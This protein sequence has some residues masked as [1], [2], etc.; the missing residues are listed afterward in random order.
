M[1]R[2]KEESVEL[3]AP[4]PVL[5]SLKKSA[6]WVEK[7]MKPI[8]GGFAAIL[9]AVLG[10]EYFVSKTERD[11]SVVTTKLTEA[12]RSY[13]EAMEPSKILSSTVAGALD[14]DY[15][16]AR[17]K[18]SAI[19]KEHPGSGASRLAKLYEADLA[20]RLGKHA[21]AEALY[22]S[23]IAEAKN[24]DVLLFLAIEGAGY[25]L[26]EQGKLDE[27]IA[28]FGKLGD[29]GTSTRF[30]KDYGLKHKARILEKKGDT[31]GAIA[32]YQS[33]VAMEPASDL[34]GFAEDRMKSLQ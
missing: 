24:D 10:Y 27:A 6:G 2:K 16:K 20:R 14:K 13:E 19:S 21:D 1:A 17:E 15:E 8:V 28:M 22:K 32:A 34:K 23:Y 11:A 4:D 5:D 3:I 7:N 25:A 29:D 33:I 9:V 26:E 18:F 31:A 12:V 30:Y